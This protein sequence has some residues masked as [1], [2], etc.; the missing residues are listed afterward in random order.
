MPTSRFN[1]KDAEPRVMKWLK[2]AKAIDRVDIVNASH[3][4]QESQPEQVANAIV[5]FI[6]KHH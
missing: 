3:F 6:S 4:V 1:N 2:K 5:N